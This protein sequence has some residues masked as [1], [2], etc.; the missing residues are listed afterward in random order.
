MMFRSTF[1]HFV[2]PGH[3]NNYRAR[4]L[5]TPAL[6]GFLACLVVL[7]LWLLLVGH[8]T[9]SHGVVLGYTS[10]ITTLQVLSQTNQE[11]QNRGLEA[12]VENTLL[13]QAAQHKAAD[14]L[15]KQYWAH[16]T[17]SGEEPWAFIDEVG[18]S[19][20]LAGEN[21]ARDFDTTPR[22]VEAWMRS[23]THRANIVHPRYTQTGIGLAT[24]MLDG[25]QTTVVVQLFALPR[26][27]GQDPVIEGSVGVVGT[28]T[29]QASP[30]SSSLVATTQGVAQTVS[31]FLVLQVAIGIVLTLLVILFLYDHLVASRLTLGRNVGASTAHVLVFLVVI[32]LL[33]SIKSGVVI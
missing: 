33:L 6:L 12:L 20:Q 17:P 22:M 13:S 29:T 25:V 21:L 8:T 11:R 31:P 30:T 16:T 15:E 9:S 7:P 24:G 3:T 14:M 28:S 18:Y 26:L 10:S 1:H 32:A 19:Y 5:H 2:T 4:L 27:V 23:P